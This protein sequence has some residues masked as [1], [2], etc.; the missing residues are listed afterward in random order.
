M[1]FFLHRHCCLCRCHLAT[2]A[3][4]L[5]NNFVSAS[6][7][8]RHEGD[9]NN[10]VKGFIVVGAIAAATVALGAPVPTA[11]PLETLDITIVEGSGS[12][13]LSGISGNLTIKQENGQ[14]YYELDYRL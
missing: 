7:G 9:G 10:P 6:I 1:L 5:D 14:H 4:V 13:E 11:E 12:G 8:I 2:I 3:F